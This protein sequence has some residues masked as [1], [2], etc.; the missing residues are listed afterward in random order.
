VPEGTRIGGV[1]V[2]GLDRDTA[3]ARLRARLATPLQ[4]S[5]TVSVDGETMRI[6]PR[7]ARVSL[8]IERA[9]DQAV[10]FGGRGNFLLRGWREL[11]GDE[12]P[13]DARLRVSVDAKAVRAFVAGMAERVEV[14]ARDAELAI[15]L[16]SVGV[17]PAVEGQRL[18]DPDGLA[19]EIVRTL[20][21]PDASRELTAEVETVEPAV[22][23]SSVWEQHPTVVTVSRAATTVRVFERGELVK[24][25]GVAVGQPRYPTPT[26]TF[27]VQQMQVDPP[28]NV[29][30]SDWA[31][32]LAG[33]TIPGGAPDNPLKERW[34]GFNGSVGFHGTD[35]VGS[36]GSAASHGCVRM[37]RAD[38]I[39]LYERVDVGTTVYVA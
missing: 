36:L 6:G 22:S 35:D 19:R 34:I 23:E 18:A 27:T 16:E 13:S 3:V 24:T 38:V 8:D 17:S 14:P 1:D 30:Q 5:V 33:R 9:V 28:W 31:G 32:D 10:D 7:R 37:S 29:P 4:R 21:S 2:G 12:V 26:G 20:K 11:T 15:S 25:Y 39:D